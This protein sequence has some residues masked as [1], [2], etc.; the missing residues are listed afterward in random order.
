MSSKLRAIRPEDTPAAPAPDSLVEA[1]KQ[2]RR[3]F[4]A[5]ARRDLAAVLDA[6]VPPHTIGRLMTELS[7]F[8]AEIRRL[9]SAP[10]EDDPVAAV[11]DGKFDYKA[12]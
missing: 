5:K 1:V 2:D 11:E 3:T 8:D 10:Q 4:L 7:A 9:D 12:I 6:G